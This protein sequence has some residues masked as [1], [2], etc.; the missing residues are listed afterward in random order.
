[1]IPSYELLGLQKVQHEVRTN[2][3]KERKKDDEIKKIWRQ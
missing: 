3:D 2:E 1:M